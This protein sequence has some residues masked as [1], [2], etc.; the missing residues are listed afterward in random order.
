[1][2][3]PGLPIRLVPV[4]A[5][6]LDRAACRLHAGAAMLIVDGSSA[7]DVFA[8]TAISP[9]GAEVTHALGRLSGPYAAGALVGEV[10]LRSYFLAADSATGISNLRRADNGGPSFPLV[11]HAVTLSFQ[12]FGDATPPAVISPAD[13]LRRTV[14]Y[15]PMPPPIGTDNPLDVWPAG[16]NCTF[17]VDGERQVARLAALSAGASGFASLPLPI[18]ADGPWCPDPISPNRYDADLLRIRLVRVTLRMQAQSARVRGM[19]A[20]WFSNPG[21]ARDSSRLVP[22]LEVTL[23]VA[24]RSMRR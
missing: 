12:Y 5:C 9:D 21:T 10:N 17:A 4:S 14:S 6:G 16:E 2:D 19:S 20:A 8:A 15:G 23:D 24:P 11:D 13:P 3:D 1:V 7:F 22:D 18:F